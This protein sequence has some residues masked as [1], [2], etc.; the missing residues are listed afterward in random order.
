[1]ATFALQTFWR[2]IHKWA[3]VSIKEK[4]QFA[5]CFLI[6]IL[7]TM[8]QD[9]SIFSYLNYFRSQR[10]SMQIIFTFRTHS[11]KKE[12]YEHDMY[13]CVCEHHNFQTI[14]PI[15]LAVGKCVIDQSCKNCIIFCKNRRTDYMFNSFC[16]HF[17]TVLQTI[18]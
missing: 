12:L 7:F 4:I 5:V 13:E 1:M 18:L 16:N 17:E 9:Y 11:E 14:L 6:F 3:D 10:W 8:S 15:E 2:S